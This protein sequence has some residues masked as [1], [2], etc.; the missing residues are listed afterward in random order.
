MHVFRQG[1]ETLIHLLW[2]NVQF[3]ARTIW[4]ILYII[5][6]IILQSRISGLDALV[7][8]FLIALQEDK[9]RQTLWLFILFVL[10][11]EGASS[12]H[13][14]S[15]VLWYGGQI[16][17]FRSGQRLFVVDN[18]IFIIFLSVCLGGYHYLLIRL[19]GELQGISIEH[20]RLVHESIIQAISIPVIWII[21]QA[22][23]P[24]EKVFGSR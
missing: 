9:F 3:M 5:G 7:P 2:Q 11:Q 23:R 10:I 1:G 8:G 17:L 24:R 13:F 22:T 18:L 19:M 12:I 15:A 21:A 4:W 20:T 16:V 6:A 14:G